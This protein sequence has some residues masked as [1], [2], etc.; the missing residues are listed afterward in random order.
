MRDE[1]LFAGAAAVLV[2]L[3]LA[4][5]L[6]LPREYRTIQR[7][8][9]ATI[10]LVWMFCGTHCG[11]VVLAAWRS[12]WH[13]VV[14]ALLAMG[15]GV[16]LIAIGGAMHLAAILVFGFRRQAGLDTSRLVTEGIY[17]WSR[18]PLLVSWTL[19]LSG[20]GLL[21]GSAMVVLLAAL[22]FL[23]YRLALPVEEELL[24]RLHGDSYAGYSRRTPRYFG[25]PCEHIS[26]VEGGSRRTV[27]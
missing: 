18:N 4:I 14:P 17:R 12:T 7:P 15:G 25:R 9:L 6:R 10:A 5:A 13:F 26:H 3:G 11:L 1:W 24:L 20:V 21:R 8:S 16:A 23:S 22:L 27:G 2:T 19:L